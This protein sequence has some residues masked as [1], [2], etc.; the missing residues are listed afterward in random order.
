MTDPK[1]AKIFVEETKVDILAISIGNRHGLY[2][3]KAELDLQRVTRIN[4]LVSVP[5]ALHGGSDLPEDLTRKSIELGIK[6]YNIGTDLKNAF[7]VIVK[8]IINQETP[9]LFQLPDILG[10]ARE[11]VFEV[12]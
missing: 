9:I 2:R 10:A 8:R 11:A 1:M 4:K 6:K 5:L 12:A 7:A 3:S